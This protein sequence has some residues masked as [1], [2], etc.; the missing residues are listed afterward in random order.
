MTHLAAGGEGKTLEERVADLEAAVEKLT[1]PY[2]P[3]RTTEELEEAV[4][5]LEG[6]IQQV[7]NE[8]L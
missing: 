5:D 7:E 4:E 3:S 6:R 1:M 8:V 2:T